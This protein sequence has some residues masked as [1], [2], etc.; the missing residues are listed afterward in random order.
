VRWEDSGMSVVD[1][2]KSRVEE[3]DPAFDLDWETAKEIERMREQD[4]LAAE[5]VVPY[6]GEVPF[7]VRRNGEA[8]MSVGNP[9][10]LEIADEKTAKGAVRAWRADHHEFHNRQTKRTAVLKADWGKL[11]SEP[12]KKKSGNYAAHYAAVCNLDT[13]FENGAKMWEEDPRNGSKDIRAYAKYGCPFAIGQDIYL[14]KITTKEYA[15]SKIADGI[16]SIETISVEKISV[17]GINAGIT[18]VEGHELDPDASRTIGEQLRRLRDSISQTADKAQWGEPA[19]KMSVRHLYTGSAADY[20]KPS[21]VHVGDGKIID[22]GL[23]V[24]NTRTEEAFAMGETEQSAA[25]LAAGIE[26][27]EAL[28]PW[29]AK[30]SPAAKAGPIAFDAADLVMFWRAVS[31]STRNPHVQKGDLPR[32]RE[33]PGRARPPHPRALRAARPDGRGRRTLRRARPSAPITNS[34]S[35]HE[36]CKV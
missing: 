12:A 3:G 32:G 19:V 9:L 31:G 29:T 8:R 2:V 10:S 24:F 17:G 21:L 34:P 11:F 22:D 5:D 27:A 6:E 33:E 1:Y 23:F 30:D 18:S 28:R 26:R 25:G 13:L 35:R 14:A 4:A 36:W 16:Y 20:E 15:D 7:S